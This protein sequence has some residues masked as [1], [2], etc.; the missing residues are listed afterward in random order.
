MLSEIWADM[1]YFYML[2]GNYEGGLKVAK[3]MAANQ[4]HINTP[5]SQALAKD[6]LGLAFYYAGQYEQARLLFEEAIPAYTHPGQIGYQ[7]FDRYI[8]TCIDLNTGN[9]QAVLDGSAFSGILVDETYQNLILLFKGFVHLVFSDLDQAEGEFRRYLDQVKAQPRFDM[10]G[11]PLAM[12]GF[13]AYKR[14][15]M[16]VCLDFLEQALVNGLEYGFFFVFMLALSVLALILAE[17]KDLIG[18]V[19]LFSTVMAHPFT[20]NSKLIDDLFGKPLAELTIGLPIESLVAAKMRGQGRVLVEFGKECLE[21][22]M[23]SPGSLDGLQVRIHRSLG[24]SGS[25]EALLD[26]NP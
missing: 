26:Q 25:E 22:L 24:L 12:F 1:G 23:A 18:A 9:Y 8:L 19:E 21:A 14:G 15:N 17:R 6:H 3:E 4:M 20:R 11:L 2:I 16:E 13:I 7:M 5:F 10:V